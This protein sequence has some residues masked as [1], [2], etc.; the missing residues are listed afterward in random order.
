[1]SNVV[2]MHEDS[3]RALLEKV[4]KAYDE[5]SIRSIILVACGYDEEKEQKILLPLVSDETTISE[6]CLAAQIVQAYASNCVSY[7]LATGER[8]DL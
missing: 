4:L 8:R 1:M 7:A 5:G 2:N 3:T 6:A